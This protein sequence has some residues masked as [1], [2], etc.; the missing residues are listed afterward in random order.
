[1]SILCEWGA[2]RE[3]EVCRDSCRGLAVRFFVVV[4]CAI[5]QLSSHFATHLRVSLTLP[6]KGVFA[7]HFTT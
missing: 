1:M 7:T 6:L 4:N 3:R 2:E 5:S